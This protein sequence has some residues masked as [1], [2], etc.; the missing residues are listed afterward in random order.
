MT[1]SSTTN[2]A[3]KNQTLYFSVPLDLA[4]RIDA[5]AKARG[6]TKRTLFLEMFHAWEVEDRK[7]R[8]DGSG[9]GRETGREA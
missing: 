9:K 5:A 4:A 1:S 8:L 7:R 6:I 3:V 2:R